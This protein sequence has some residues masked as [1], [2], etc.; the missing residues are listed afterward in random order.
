[1]KINVLIFTGYG[2]SCMSY[3]VQNLL[4]NNK[5]CFPYNRIISEE[6]LKEIQLSAKNIL[7]NFPKDDIN[8]DCIV[9]LIEHCDNLDRIFYFRNYSTNTLESFTIAEVDTSRPWKIENY[10]GAEYIQYLDYEVKH[11]DINYCDYKE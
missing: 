2:I 1:M 9:R 5:L 4:I 8:R 7:D 11:K 10:D 6:K 3:K